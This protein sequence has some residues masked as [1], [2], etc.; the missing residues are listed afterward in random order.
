MGE[1]ALRLDDPSILDEPT[2]VTEIVKYSNKIKDIGHGFNKMMAP[3]Y[4]RDFI[5]AYDI[6]ST[7]LAKA[8]QK[9]MEADNQLQVAESI[10]YLEN[11]K[12]YLDSK[13]IK[14]TAE[15]R[16]RY[17]PLD[18]A[19]AMAL[20]RKARTTAMV[21]LFRTKLQEFRFAIE[22]VKKIAYSDQYL[23]PDEGM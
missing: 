16:K 5:I 13:D 1:V 3:L 7:A 23:S 17:V 2:D 12:A 10:A 21:S 6:T 8:T 4:L 9:D 15:A 22:S 20:D 14:D 18:A 11:A 19:V